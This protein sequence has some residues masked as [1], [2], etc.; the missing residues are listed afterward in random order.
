MYAAHGPHLRA[1]SRFGPL[2]KLAAAPGT[3]E[4]KQEFEKILT[5]LESQ[6]LP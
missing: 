4:A 5:Q 2:P 3:T 1:L 6:A